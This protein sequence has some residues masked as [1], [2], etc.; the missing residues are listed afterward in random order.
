MIDWSSCVLWLDNKYFSE[1]KWWDRSKY[2]ND[3][4]VYGAKFKEDGFYFDGSND[5]IKIPN[6]I[7]PNNEEF[8]IF[9]L[10]YPEGENNDNTYNEQVI[11]D[12]RGQY[13][14]Y[15][16]WIE[17]DDSSYPGCIRGWIDDGS[18]PY[19]L[20]SPDNSVD[21][22]NWHFVGLKFKEPT[23]V[24]YYD[25]NEISRSA[26]KP[27]TKSGYQSKIGKDCTTMDRLWFKG[28]IKMVLIFE[29][30]ISKEESDV[31]YRNV[32]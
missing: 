24:V 3:G 5:Y 22:M 15:I 20:Y 10:I 1:Y 29:K 25:G 23:M 6:D 30:Y 11:V 12:L 9:A 21:T 14:I 26:N 17:E 31:L 27:K 2:N 19:S 13:E 16:S 28:M 7:L 32:L 18:V 8:S 4:V